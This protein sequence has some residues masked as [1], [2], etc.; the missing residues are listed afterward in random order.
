M[1][2]L[3]NPVLGWAVGWVTFTFLVIVAS[4]VDYAIASAVASDLFHYTGTAGNSW[5]ITA[6]VLLVQALLVAYSTR[7]SE[8]I[9]NFAVTAELAGIV[10][11]VVRLI[12]G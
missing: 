8:R 7:W 10:A 9:N 1:S 4:A 3:A 6:A 12:V 11:L 2:R 5:A